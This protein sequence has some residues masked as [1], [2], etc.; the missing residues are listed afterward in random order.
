MSCDEAVMR[1]MERDVRADYSTS[2]LNLATGRFFPGGTPLAFG[3]G[4]TKA[5]IHNVMRW[6]RPKPVLTGIALAVVMVAAVILGTDP[7]TSD[8]EAA[9]VENEELWRLRMRGRKLSVTGTEMRL[10]SL[11]PRRAGSI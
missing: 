11:V 8:V 6:R 9:E 5:R 2:L 10:R 1:R 3:E 7:Q 4:D